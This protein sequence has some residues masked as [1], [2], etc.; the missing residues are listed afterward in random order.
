M[1][2]LGASRARVAMFLAVEAGAMLAGA[3]V[4]AVAISSAAPG[5]APVVLR[6]AVGG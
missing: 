6:V 1:K 2:R 5:V 4:I 3:V